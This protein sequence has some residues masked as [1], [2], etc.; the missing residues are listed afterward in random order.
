MGGQYGPRH[1][2]WQ[3]C[4]LTGENSESKLG[5]FSGLCFAD[6][7][8]EKCFMPGPASKHV[9]LV[10]YLFRKFTLS[11]AKWWKKLSKSDH[12]EAD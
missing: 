6:I 7:L 3:R 8:G 2:I 5:D 9:T 12:F 1:Y 10:W 4:D 11:G